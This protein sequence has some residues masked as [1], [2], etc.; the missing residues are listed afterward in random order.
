MKGMRKVEVLRAACC[1][2]GADGEVT[3]AERRLLQQLADEVGV[4]AASLAAMIERATTDE[5]YYADQ[6][7]VLKSDP[8][9]TLQLLFQVAIADR[10]LSRDEC[11]CLKRLA[12]RLELPDEQFDRWLAA[13][14]E[15]ARQ[16]EQ[17][18]RSR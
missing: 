15:A 13:T 18:K 12:R 16:Q 4:G 17:A 2:A 9:Q 1:V 8:E 11:L 6:F 3:D 5:K 14:V 10:R 7:R